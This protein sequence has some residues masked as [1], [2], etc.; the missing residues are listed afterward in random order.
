MLRPCQ[1]GEYVVNLQARVLLPTRL[2]QPWG[3]KGGRCLVHE[4]L[5][6]QQDI[7]K[8]RESEPRQLRDIFE[9]YKGSRVNR[10]LLFLGNLRA[11]SWIT[12]LVGRRG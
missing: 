8:D 11:G 5:Q 2:C 9:N 7:F 12:E 10:C 4:L 6:P 3:T 1:R